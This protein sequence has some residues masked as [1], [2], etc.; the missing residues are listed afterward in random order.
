[1]SVKGKGGRLSRHQEERQRTKFRK[2][3]RAAG[4]PEERVEAVV[5]GG[6]RD[7]AAVDEVLR[8]RGGAEP[9]ATATAQATPPGPAQL[10]T[11]EPS[12]EELQAAGYYYKAFFSLAA[13]VLNVPELNVS[14]GYMD[15]M[16]VRRPAALVIRKRFPHGAEPEAQLFVASGP[17]LM[18][19]AQAYAT[20]RAQAL[21]AL[22]ARGAGLGRGDGARAGTGA[23]AVAGNGRRAPAGEPAHTGAEGLREDESVEVIGTEVPPEFNR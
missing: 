6:A 5:T 12:P 15:A 21:A 16:N 17:H 8:A 20:R 7:A 18:K 1:V 19:G 4:V 2:V 11:G 9:D 23:G 3:L 14:D 10:P 22:A 13:L